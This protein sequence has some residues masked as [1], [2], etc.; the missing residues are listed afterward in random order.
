M[1]S[2]QV[3]RLVSLNFKGDPT[4]KGDDDGFRRVRATDGVGVRS[5]ADALIL[6]TQLE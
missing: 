3:W 4:N 5:R 1:V 2:P 6:R